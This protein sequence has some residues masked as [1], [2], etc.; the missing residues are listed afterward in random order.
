VIFDEALLQ[1]RHHRIAYQ[2]TIE[3]NGSA[4]VDP[5]FL[6]SLVETCIT[7]VLNGIDRVDGV[8]FTS[9][10]GNFLGVDST[11]QPLTSISTY[12]DTRATPQ[13]Q[14]LTQALDPVATHQRTG[15]PPHTAYHPP[16]LQ[17]YHDEGVQAARWIDFATFCYESW[18]G[19]IAP[20]SYSIASWSGLFN[21]ASCEWDSLWLTQLGLTPDQLPPLAEFSAGYP[22]DQL[23]PAYREQ[24]GALQSAMFYLAVG[25]GA[26][27]NI[28]S[29]AINGDLALTVGTTAAIRQIISATDPPPV[30]PGL[31]GYR[32]TA[33][34]HLIGG[35]T[36]EGG[37]LYGWAWRTL[38]LPSRETLESTIL[39]MRPT[40]HGLTILPFFGGERSP[41]YNPLAVG[42]I[43]G[44]RLN[45]S[46]IDIFAA[47]LES[48]ALRLALIAER[49]TE[50]QT[51]THTVYATGGALRA[52]PVWV[53]LIS[54]ALN[55][56]VT[57]IDD[58]EGTARGGAILALNALTGSPLNA[59]PVRVNQIM[60]P[61]PSAVEAL[62]RA[63]ESQRALYDQVN[64][65]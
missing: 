41:G 33:T 2:F 4:T 47:L 28:G 42:V 40:A 45:T 46:P 9:F 51:V 30:P 5:L 1:L 21:R 56:P 23:L 65:F 38:Q 44:V 32:V 16:R 25:D 22:G 15:C 53:Q 54:D 35:A 11:S 39:E 8:A 29:G 13:L 34:D 27:A 64:H 63:G 57:L 3:P 31:W 52:S 24:W 62:R 10:V 61:R 37:N 59:Y 20:C 7:T 43:H 17:M 19:G 55:R 48:V 12:A 36:T 26:A 60:S 49:L 6:R 50:N 18:F 14:R 58:S